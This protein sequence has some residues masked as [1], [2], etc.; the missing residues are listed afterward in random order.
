MTKTGTGSGTVTSSP[1]GINCGTD[2][3]QNYIYGTVVT[4]TAQ[5]SAGSI[6]TGWSGGGC[7]GTGTCTVTMDSA[8]TCTAAFTRDR[9]TGPPGYT[10]VADEGE[11]FTFTE[12]VDVAYGA[13]GQFYYMY[14]V[15]GTITFDNATFGD[16]IFDVAKA[17][18]YKNADSYPIG[19]PGYTYVAD[20]DESFTFTETVDVAYGAN[21]QFYYM[22]GVTGTITF[23][24]ATFG[25]PI[26]DVVKAGF[27]K[28]A[29]SYPI[30]P[31]R[32]TYVADEG[33]SFT[34]TE[35]VD[36]AYGAN[37]QFYYMYGVTGTIT[38]DNA[39]FGDPIFDV[40]KAGFYKNADSDT[41]KSNLAEAPSTAVQA[42]DSPLHRVLAAAA[43]SP[44][45][46]KGRQR[47]LAVGGF[48]AGTPK[49]RDAHPPA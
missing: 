23:D 14:G 28:N 17:G 27:Y 41:D 15:T 2:C 8:K 21:G 37:G 5:A 42:A 7:S 10:Y 31:S 46:A 18:F 19:P 9:P 33:E 45:D 36:V 48:L 47:W 35:T 40:A 49:D 6:F 1:A 16:P 44:P 30:G 25:D 24:N 4:L 13:N 3:S 43:L 20:E 39:T 29:D 12:T 22:Y 32:Y 38:F 26:F 11:S 34:F